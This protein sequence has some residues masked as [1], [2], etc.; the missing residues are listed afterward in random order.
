AGVRWAADHG[1]KVIS[2]SL[3]GPSYSG[4]LDNA[5]QYAW[6]KGCVIVAAAGNSASTSFSYP[7]PYDHVRPVAATDS[8]ERLCSFSNYGCWVKVAAPGSGVLS[9]TPTY[10]VSGWPLYYAYASGTSMATPHVAGEAA[11][12]I[13]Q[14]PNISNN[15][16]SSVILSNVDPYTPYN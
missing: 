10:A 15:Q 12:L 6:S 7:A 11:L 16:V 5:V 14:N 8:T 2:M 4:T 1:A 13:A 9:T 3:G